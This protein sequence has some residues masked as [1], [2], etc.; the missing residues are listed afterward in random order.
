MMNK[1]IGGMDGVLFIYNQIPINFKSLCI[2]LGIF[3]RLMDV[4]LTVT[5]LEM[6][7][8]EI[9]DSVL[10]I[11]GKRLVPQVHK[12]SLGHINYITFK[13]FASA[14]LESEVYFDLHYF[15]SFI[16]QFN[17]NKQWFLT[18]LSGG[19]IFKDQVEIIATFFGKST[20]NTHRKLY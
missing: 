2:R 10:Q 9:F 11:H 20:H 7:S 18:F 16:Y 6:S 15:N 17:P 1:V 13:E 14:F 12:M 4:P 5:L 19:L 3:L 8:L